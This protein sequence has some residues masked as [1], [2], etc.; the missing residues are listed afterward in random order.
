MIFNRKYWKIV[1]WLIAMRKKH[2]TYSFKLLCSG[3]EII[4]YVEG[5]ESKEDEI[6]MSIL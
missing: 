5:S 2:N 6:R 1:K 3:H 4:I